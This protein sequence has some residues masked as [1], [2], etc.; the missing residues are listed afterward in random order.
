MALW[1]RIEKWI[2]RADTAATILQWVGL[3]KPAVALLGAL[4][5]IAL[6][7]LQHIPL[8]YTLAA[9]VVI[10]S[11]ILSSFNNFDAWATRNSIQEHFAFATVII[12]CNVKATYPNPAK[13]NYQ[14]GVVLMNTGPRR[15]HYRMN[16]MH[17]VIGG[18]GIARPVFES[19]SGV[20]PPGRSHEY[21]YAEIV[22]VDTSEGPIEGTIDFDFSYG[23]SSKSL[24][25]QLKQKR[26]LKIAWDSPDKSK[27][28][29][30]VQSIE[31]QS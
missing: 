6:G 3:W 22:D 20:V 1:E 9:S 16:D 26:S 23:R 21:Y 10:F 4:V 2:G 25:F 24:P 27:P 14:P 5:A 31:I 8:T 30:V 29:N 19:K 18:R 7:L 13:V 12:R 28:P 17:A 15:V 11:G